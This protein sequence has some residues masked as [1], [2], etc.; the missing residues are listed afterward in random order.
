MRRNSLVRGVIR[1][2]FAV[3]LKSGEGSFSG[4]LTEADAA[5]YIFE[6]CTTVPSKPGETVD[7]IPGRV[8]I[9]RSNVAYMQELQS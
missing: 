7:D 9:D 5:V 6:A 3:T 1:H 2:R 8:I 4:V